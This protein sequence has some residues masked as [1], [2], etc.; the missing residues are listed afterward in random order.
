MLN[1]PPN[2][3]VDSAIIYIAQYKL[4]GGGICETVIAMH[5]NIARGD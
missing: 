1:I 3:L 4:S 5:G 2:S